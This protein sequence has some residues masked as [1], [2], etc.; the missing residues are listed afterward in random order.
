MIVLLTWLLYTSGSLLIFWLVYYAG[1]RN[2]TFYRWNR[3]YLLATLCISMLVPLLERPGLEREITATT[4]A[5]QEETVFS[6]IVLPAVAANV[7][8]VTAQPASLNL[9]LIVYLSGVGLMAIG[10]IYGLVR[11]ISTIKRNKRKSRNGVTLVYTP[12]LNASFFHFIFLQQQLAPQE[13]AMIL[14]HEDAHRR[15]LHSFDLLFI[16]LAKV[17]FWFNPVIYCYQRA[18]RDVHECEADELATSN[19]SK[20]DYAEMLLRFNERNRQRSVV[21]FNLYSE[22]PLKKRI[23]FLFNNK[24]N[25]MKKALYLFVL[26]CLAL[27]VS[28]FSAGIMKKAPVAAEAKLPDGARF[29]NDEKQVTLELDIP[30]LLGKDAAA[31]GFDI[32]TGSEGWKEVVK[33]FDEIGFKLSYKTKAGGAILEEVTLLL[34]SKRNGSA[35]STFRVKDMVEGSYHYI[36][37]SFDKKSSQL[38]LNTNKEPVI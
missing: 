5:I 34:E 14:R 31:D 24:S 36:R 32:L 26:P 37:I 25:K 38:Y 35:R 11:I 7:D 20:T 9:V 15:Q 13:E 27:A 22:H 23:H 21:L 28:S 6:H 33:S 2:L 3:I 29:K 19:V 17:I 8:A 12:M 30:V 18:L 1:L 16:E 4:G 10:F